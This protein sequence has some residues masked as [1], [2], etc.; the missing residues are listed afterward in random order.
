MQLMRAG[1]EFSFHGRRWNGWSINH[2][3]QLLQATKLCV[4]SLLSLP[5]QV[6]VAIN[7]VNNT[8]FLFGLSV[9]ALYKALFTTMIISLTP[10]IGSQLQI[11]LRHS[12]QIQ[13]R[14][15]SFSHGPGCSPRCSYRQ[16][17]WVRIYAHNL[18][19]G[20]PQLTL[21]VFFYWILIYTHYAPP[22]CQ[23]YPKRNFIQYVHF[24]PFL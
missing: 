2:S 23:N 20:M 16:W 8:S 19:D 22:V 4:E 21:F 15:Q 13:A 24:H 10:S 11:H 6:C 3:H 17:Q 7:N 5:I 18:F 12:N 14:F 1:V 9:L